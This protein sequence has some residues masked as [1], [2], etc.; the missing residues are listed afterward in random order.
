MGKGWFLMGKKVKVGLIGLG[1]M[2]VKHFSI[3]RKFPDVEVAAVADADPAHLRGDVS[4]VRLNGRR[5]ADDF[6]DL[7]GAKGFPDA[8]LMIREMPEL[9]MIDICLPTF[10]HPSLI[11]AG[12]RAGLPVFCEKPLCLDMAEAEPL[13]EEI[14]GSGCFFN[15]GL[16][17]RMSPEYLHAREYIRSGKAGRILS[18]VF[19]RFSPKLNGWFV[20]EKKTGG[21]LLDLHIHDT[22]YINSLFGRPFAVTAHG[23]RNAV[24]PESGIDQICAVYHYEN[25]PFVMAEGGWAASPDVPF[26]RS[27]LIIGEKATLQLNHDGY[28]I[29]GQEG[30]VT[31]PELD[32]SLSDGWHAELKYFT[33][34]VRQG[35]VP[36]S[37][38]SL[39]SLADTYRILMAER[40]SVLT[41]RTVV[42]AAGTGAEKHI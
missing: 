2:G 21:A 6:L 19:R 3:Y 12:L 7:G 11:R 36:D 10:L 23:V 20:S 35:I 38:Q 33:D 34:C 29:F 28:K 15:L 37:Y 39:E 42:V 13:L 31:V 30:G 27:F 17:V 41:N 5:I 1:A 26:E 18:A 24:S 16:C 9:D 14:R 32:R 4:N 8:E 25:G 22:D 40:E